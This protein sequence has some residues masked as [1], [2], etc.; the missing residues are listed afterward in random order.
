MNFSKCLFYQAL[1]STIRLPSCRRI[2]WQLTTTWWLRPGSLTTRLSPIV[3]EPFPAFWAA[4]SLILLS[5]AVQTFY[6][7]WAIRKIYVIVATQF[8]KKRYFS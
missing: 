5:I 3:G 1:T 6:A 2:F 8:Y 7:V 4:I